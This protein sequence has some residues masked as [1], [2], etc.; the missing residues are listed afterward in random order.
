[1]LGSM[2]TGALSKPT[3]T[4]AT[5]SENSFKLLTELSS[6]RKGRSTLLEITNPDELTQKET[7]ERALELAN[8]LMRIPD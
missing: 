1:M 5:T 4:V 8:I 7:C 6:L 2:D 3:S